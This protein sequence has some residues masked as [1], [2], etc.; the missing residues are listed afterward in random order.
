MTASSASRPVGPTRLVVLIAVALAT[1]A[2]ATAGA[3][4][5]G[6]R[7]ER[8]RDY[9]QAVIAYTRALQE[10]PHDRNIQLAL[11]RARL[12]A[13]QMHY[14]EGRRLEREAR[15][16]DALTE[17]Q[18]AYDLNPGMA[19]I[20]RAIREMRDA[21][22][23]ELT[24]LPEGQ[25]AL[26]ALIESTL[27]AAPPGLDLPRG[28]VLPDSVV[29]SGESSRAVFSALGQLGDVSVVF[30]AQ[31]RDT[32]FSGDL[33][34][35]TF[36]AALAVVATSTGNFFRVTAP[37]T[38]TIIP[39]TPAKRREYEEEIIRTFY[40]SNADVAET[41]DLLRLVVDLRRLAPVTATNAISIKDTPERIDAAARLIR[42]IDKARAEVVIEV[43]LLEV[44]RQTLRDYGLRFI[45]SGDNSEIGAGESATRDIDTNAPASGLGL[46][47]DDVRRVSGS[48]LFVANPSSLLVR[49]LETNGNT[50]ILA[51][52]QLRTSDGVAAEAHFGERVPVP[53]TTFTPIAAGG[54]S[55][56]PITSF[57][58]EEIGVNI[59]I[60]PRV[61]HND[62]VSLAIEVEISNISGTGFGDLPQFGSR[63][64]ITMIRLRDGE[65]NILAGL[66]RDDERETQEGIPGLSRIPIL[67]RLFGRT[68]TDTQETDIVLTLKPHIIR[69][70]SL[71]EY[72]L[73]PFRVG[74]NAAVAGTGGTTS[75]PGAVRPQPQPQPRVRP[76]QELPGQP[77][78]APQR[79]I[80]APPAADPR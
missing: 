52:P 11:D 60:T 75:P 27:A 51:N 45:S 72:D 49:L 1:S 67:G 23:A 59:V 78:T 4:R 44:D 57:N 3:L 58:Y 34:D 55:Q 5:D 66:I 38:V 63:S 29:F 9:D 30:D 32:P 36:D 64:I 41:I 22:R 10:R 7:A 69:A 61:H 35:M 48:N 40:L 79:P 13:A 47:V 25:T 20:E 39:D 73:R 77:T 50:R 12:R 53:V 2:C 46:S 31:F 18:I 68:R 80:A 26:E 54:I 16:E 37:G 15:W 17:Y 76:G 14:A 19:D 33:R 24:A 21:V 71:E 65:T 42:A 43:Q 56:Q 8:A 62:E 74:S 6:Q 70:L 28:I